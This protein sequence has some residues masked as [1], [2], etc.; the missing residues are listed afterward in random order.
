[1]KTMQLA[2]SVLS[3]IL[4]FAV[5]SGGTT[6]HSAAAAPKAAG[7][8]KFAPVLPV[9]QRSCAAAIAYSEAR[10]GVSVLVLQNGVRVCESYSAGGSATT[11]QQLWSGTKSFSGVMAAIA[12]K[13]GLFTL[14]EKA[15]DTITEWKA[16]PLKS[17]ITIRQLLSLTSGL[18]NET[19]SRPESYDDALKAPIRTAPGTAFAYGP[20]NYQV[21]GAL[22]TRKLRARGLPD[23]PATYL[24]GKLLDPLGMNS[25]TWRR[26]RSGDIML[27][28]GMALTARDWAKFGEFV[29]AGGRINGRL[30]VDPAAF[31]DQFKGSAVHA[32]YGLTWWLPRPS[33]QT[34]VTTL[35]N[36]IGRRSDQ[37]PPDTVV[38]GGAGDQRLYVIP[39]RGLTI[40]RQAAFDPRSALAARRGGERRDRAASEADDW[41]DATFISTVLAR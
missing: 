28:Q 35:R 32:G 37:F 40:V 34:D 18:V 17:A 24:R 22:L 27:P 2:W 8:S 33:S 15:S 21:F 38:A 10:R 16:D 12:V 23:D 4:G 31:A 1:L 9:L 6:A 19:P 30:V 41:S 14:D 5:F 36:D 25:A 13:D 7:L 20:V 29:R 39:S 3:A 26:T 11:T